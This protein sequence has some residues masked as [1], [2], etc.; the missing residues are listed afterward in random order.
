MAGVTELK[1]RFVAAKVS[2]W[3][4]PIPGEAGRPDTPP[5]KSLTAF[6]FTEHDTDVCKVKLGTVGRNGVSDDDFNRVASVAMGLEFGAPCTA[7]C[8]PLSYGS[9]RLHSISTPGK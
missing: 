8:G 3:S 2:E 7:H 6:V 9:Y 4:E 5:G 1:G